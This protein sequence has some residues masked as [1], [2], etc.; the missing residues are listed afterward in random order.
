VLCPDGDLDWAVYD[1]STAP[2]RF[3]L[4]EPVGP[5]LGVDAIADCDLVLVPALLVDARGYR[6]G[7]GGGSYDRALARS[8]ALT[9]ALVHD[10]ELVHALPTEPHDVP[11]GAVAT[12]SRGVVRVTGKMWSM[13]I[14]D[15]VLAAN[16]RYAAD[17]V[18]QGLPGQAGKGLA[19][20]TC[21][22]SRIDPLKMLGLA[23]GDAKIMR[24]AGG[25]V[26]PDVLRT[27]ALA[28]HL[29]GVQRILVVGHTDCRMSSATEEQVHAAIFEASGIDSRSLDFELIAD[30]KLTI[31]KDVQRVRSWPYLPKGIDVGGFLYDVKT[32][33]LTEVP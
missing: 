13:G 14:F 19:V 32:G 33:R 5:R 24:N 7:K 11:V 31:A 23:K 2:G 22:D 15:D 26:T 3:G 6:L 21:M 27:L 20:V 29:L 9:V 10:D 8:S 30:Q 25:R 12:P 28:V 4:A 1:G 16:E 17:F 18:D